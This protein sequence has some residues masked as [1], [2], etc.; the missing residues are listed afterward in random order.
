MFLL[1]VRVGDIGGQL[2][3]SVGANLLGFV[4]GCISQD[5]MS[6][7]GIGYGGSLHLWQKNSVIKWEE[8]GNRNKYDG[9][10]EK[11]E[12]VIGNTVENSEN[13]NEK[14]TVE[15]VNNSDN[16]RW[17]PVPF[18]TGHF[19][20]VNDLI[21]GQDYTRNWNENHVD[22]TNSINNKLD[23][24]SN[25]L[26]YSTETNC[27]CI[28]TVSSDQT[29]RL[30]AT[31][32]P[33]T[34]AKEVVPKKNEVVKEVV[35]KEV[36]RPQVHGYELNAI[37]SIY[38]HNNKDNDNN[39]NSSITSDNN[40][41]N[42]DTSVVLYTGNDIKNNLNAQLP[43]NIITAGDE[44]IIRIFSPPLCVIEGVNKLCGLLANS[45]DTL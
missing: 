17:Y 4:G 35:W 8:N 40:V 33:N 23:Q 26:A 6:L 41:H 16:D 5:G 12:Q 25:K 27:D 44:K 43:K 7:I 36:T 11:N 19:G 42:I 22:K 37:V 3:G 32:A 24:E 15:H 28:I 21:W 20:S 31:I 18:V 34:V 45:T 9:Y 29:C 13:N 14:N 2:G 1:Q 39:D 38:S 10:A 30:F